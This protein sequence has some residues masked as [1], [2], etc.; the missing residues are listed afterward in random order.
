MTNPKDHVAA[1]IIQAREHMERALEELK[2]LPAFDPSAVAYSAHI[3]NNFLT[4]T[5]GTV[6]MLR[7][8]L[9]DHPDP[10]VRSWLDALHQAA[11]LMSQTVAQLMG[12]SARN[13]NRLLPEKM[14]LPLMAQ[15][16]CN[17]YQKIADR[18]QIRITFESAAGTPFVLADRVALAAVLDNLMSNA[19][20]YS[21]PEQTIRVR[22]ESEPNHLV[23]RVRDEGPGL[24]ANDQSRLFQR[25]VRLSAEPTG[26]EPSSGYGL[27]VAKD[28]ME[29]L[30]GHIWCESELA[31]GACF[32]IR[33]PIYRG[34]TPTD[35]T[36]L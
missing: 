1:E 14:D 32:S 8:T 5:T 6:D 34:D 11:D 33:V 13:G 20:K 4:V 26:G 3:L 7:F 28:L 19:V 35:D 18:K 2:R 30:G 16:F 9:A 21:K 25:G 24:S 23:C 12:V 29:S 36:A 17:Y 15:R 27:A 31:K 10:Q 22:V